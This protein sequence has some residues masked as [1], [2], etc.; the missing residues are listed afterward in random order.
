MFKRF[1]IYFIAIAVSAWLI[2]GVEVESLPA[3]A[4]TAGVLALINT[5]I[6]PIVTFLSL[7]FVIF[8]GGLFLIVINAAMILLASAFVPGFAVSGFFA[9]AA[10]TGVVFVVWLILG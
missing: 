1:L 2:P 9:S 6:R 7:P 10:L 5:F 4:L 8:S 3:L